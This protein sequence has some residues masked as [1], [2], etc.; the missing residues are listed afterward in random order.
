MH[1]SDPYAYV[2]MRAG[3]QPTRLNLQVKIGTINEITQNIYCL[4]P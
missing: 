4:S 1:M 3:T 2:R